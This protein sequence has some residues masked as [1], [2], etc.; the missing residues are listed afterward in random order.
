MAGC[1]WGEAGC[2]SFGERGIFLV[3]FKT[4]HIC[5]LLLP[6]LLKT[7]LGHSKEIWYFNQLGSVPY[8]LFPPPPEAVPMFTAICL[9]VNIGPGFSNKLPDQTCQDFWQICSVQPLSALPRPFPNTVL[10]EPHLVL[11]ILLLR[12]LVVWIY[13]VTYTHV[14]GET[15]ITPLSTVTC[16]QKLL[17]CAS[18]WFLPEEYQGF[19]L[20]DKA[21]CGHLGGLKGRKHHV[22][23]YLCLSGPG[24]WTGQR[25]L[26]AV[27]A[28]LFTSSTPLGP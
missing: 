12:L 20:N 28:R 16:R 27:R 11:F 8:C 21:Q 13:M 23:S 14:K 15:Y 24:S 1:G 3:P 25:W 9:L 10:Q 17:T 22:L 5:H 4:Y 6:S 18:L 2:D 19:V 26:E 7:L